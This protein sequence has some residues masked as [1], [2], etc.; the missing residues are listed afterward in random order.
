MFTSKY[1]VTAAIAL[2]TAGGSG[3]TAGT[4][5]SSADTFE[6]RMLQSAA[7]D[8][9]ATGDF[10]GAR[11][12]YEKLSDLDGTDAHAVREAARAAA[13]IG[14][15]EYAAYALGR[16]DS[17]AG[18]ARDPELHYLRGEALYALGDRRQARRE[19]DLVERELAAVAPTRQSQLWLGRVYARRGDLA[20]ADAVYRGLTPAADQPVDVEVTLNRAEAHLMNRDW[21][22]ARQILEAM[23]ARLPDHQRARDM[24]AWALEATG[25]IDDELALRET[26]ARHQATSRQLFDYGR[27]LE[28]SGDYASALSAYQSATRLAG[29]SDD[30][31][32]AGAVRR[33]AQRT[34]MELAAAVLGRSDPQTSSL[35]E[36]V[37]F[38]APFGR[39]HHIALGAW[40]EHMTADLVPR[41]GSAGEAWTALVVH[42]RVIEAVVG[43]KLGYVDQ[44]A[45]D[46]STTSHASWAGFASARGQPARHLKFA[47]DG[48]LD[49]LWRETPLTLLEGGHVTGATANLY[50]LALDDRVIAN[51]GAQRRRL[52]LTGV[53]GGR[54]PITSQSLGWAG[55]DVVAWVDHAHALEGG[56]L[57][58]GMLWPT[59]L[60]DSLVVS[61]RHYELRSDAEPE[62]MARIS[63]V[64]RASI[65][66]GSLVARK[67]MAGDRIGVE[68][69]GGLGWDRARDV[70]TSH[71]GASLLATPT[72]SSRISLTVDVGAE[73]PHGFQWQGRTGWVSYHADL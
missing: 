20:R 72:R 35:G 10:A 21:T 43:G 56:V 30:P 1:G 2:A 15:F 44:R 42:R 28:R 16:A 55:F 70:A 14:D 49:A 46:G 59:Q 27:A 26:I 5:E 38:T 34:A 29:D 71:A 13:A 17:L 73:S 41:E 63:M 8:A 54:A 33:M 53:A 58:D 67:V 52:E 39:A 22:G 37:G 64:P 19:H 62:F 40:H 61:Y 36:Q 32:L 65:D 69:R 24:L 3:A 11:L 18:H 45:R 31:E 50:G 60:T 4:R 7:A 12:L 57:D 6:V 51:A 47:L 66:E 9:L 25:R 23:L 68:L 48:E